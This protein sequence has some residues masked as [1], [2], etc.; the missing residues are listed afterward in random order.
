MCG[1]G[2]E[3]R[4]GQHGV[5]GGG[6]GRCVVAC[7]ESYGMSKAL[8]ENFWVDCELLLCTCEDLGDSFS[9]SRLTAL[10]FPPLF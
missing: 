9:R 8:E 2:V 6:R 5:T 7:E 10:S 1:N 3:G 4:S